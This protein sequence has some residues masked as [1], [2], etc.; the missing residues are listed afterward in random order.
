[1]T[2]LFAPVGFLIVC[3][4]LV[5]NEISHRRTEQKLIDRLL[6]KEGMAPLSDPEQEERREVKPPKQVEKLIFNIP[7]MPAKKVGPLGN[8]R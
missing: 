7:G 8:E 5:S 2:P 3:A 4:M 6:E 1:L